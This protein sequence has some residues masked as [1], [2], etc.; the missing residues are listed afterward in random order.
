MSTSLREDF[1]VLGYRDFRILLAD[2]LL[3][4]LA[5]AFSLVGGSFAVLDT[6]GSTADLSYVLAAQLVPS[7]VFMLLGGVAAD[8][9]KPQSVI[10]V[11]NLL[12]A[13]GEGTFGLL[14][15]LHATNLPVMMGLEFC[16]GTG[17]SLF[18]PASTALLPKGR[19]RSRTSG[20][21]G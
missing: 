12:V 11:S 18:W 6:T 13:L 20:P 4:P 14:T 9:F 10:I 1:A 21:C 5:F 8:R 17:I 15:L 16:T 19:W 2:R 7:V 3:A